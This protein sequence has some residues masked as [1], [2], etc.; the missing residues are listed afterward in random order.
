QHRADAFE[1][2][3]H[4]DVERLL[5]E[6]KTEK[7]DGVIVDL[8]NNGGGSLAEATDLTGLF[9]DK[10]PVVQV[11]NAAGQVE[12]EEDPHPGM[13]WDGPLAVLV[14]RAS[15]SASEIFAA[16]IQ[17]YGRGVIIG[18]P[19]FGKGT[20]QNLVDLDELA[21][22]EKPEYGEVKMTIAQFFRI[23]G[24]STQL[25]GVTPDISFPLSVDASE[26]GESSYDNA[27]P[28]TS[29]APARYQTI[30][31]LKPIV[32]MLEERHTTRVAANTEWQTF[33]AEI[34]DARA[35]RSEKIVS[36][37]ENARRKERDEQEAKRKARELADTATP[38]ADPGSKTREKIM[39]DTKIGS[40][41]PK[42]DASRGT[43]AE[44]A[45][46]DAIAGGD[47]VA[48][49]RDDGLQPD[50]RGIQSDIKREQAA[51]EKRDV[52]LDEAAHILADEIAL[53]RTDTKLAARV[54]P[55][56][57]VVPTEV[58]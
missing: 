55:R 37:N 56:G 17:D 46:S 41:Q 32:P 47:E 31:D 38:Q 50:E 52:V 19:T 5:G 45:V 33:A 7:V 49:S 10:G 30:A 39:Q 18:E 20:V 58:D 22:N 40:V 4:R 9:I 6:L 35:V 1:R 8:R 54:L 15:A 11:R 24:G 29:I 12:Q 57:F 28:W 25:R 13:A 51:K 48:P 43:P 36:L 21:H 53:V 42:G 23:N 14:N 16:A 26:F 34:A 2:K 27:L 44:G 3:L